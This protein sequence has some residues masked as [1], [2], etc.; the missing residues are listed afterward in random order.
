MVGRVIILRS[1]PQILYVTCPIAYYF[2]GP[3]IILWFYGMVYWAC[4]CSISISTSSEAAI[5]YYTWV[6]PNLYIIEGGLL[7]VNVFFFKGFY[8]IIL[9]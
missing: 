8:Y 5:L 7:P 2:I 4:S 3:P 6:G 1:A 9:R